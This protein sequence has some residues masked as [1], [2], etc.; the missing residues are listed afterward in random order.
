MA[1][2]GICPEMACER[3]EVEK[4]RQPT[5]KQAYQTVAQELGIPWKTVQTWDIRTSNEAR[6]GIRKRQ[7]SKFELLE[8][9]FKSIR[10]LLATMPDFRE[11]HPGV[12]R[13]KGEWK[14]ELPN[15]QVGSLNETPEF[16]NDKEHKAL[17]HCY[18]LFYSFVNEL[19]D[20]LDK[21]ILSTYK[22]AKKKRV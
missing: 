9:R 1:H 8:D 16:F 6:K 15:G 13:E 19:G 11:N 10:R 14:I 18:F 20:Y 3:L 5:K 22:E 21:R 2:K 7:K 4:K 12:F 17:W